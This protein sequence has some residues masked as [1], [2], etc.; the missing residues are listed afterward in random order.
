MMTLIA[1]LDAAKARQDLGSDNQ[2]SRRLGHSAAS[3]VN[4]WRKGACRER[5]GT[6]TAAW[7]PTASE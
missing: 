2:L 3:M 5:M 1:Y 4:R 7:E 6:R